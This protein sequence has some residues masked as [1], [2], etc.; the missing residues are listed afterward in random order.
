MKALNPMKSIFR[1]SAT[2]LAL[3]FL[4]AQSGNARAQ[5]MPPELRA[6]I[7]RLFDGHDQ[8]VRTVTLTRDGY[9]ATTTSTNPVMAA[10]LTAHVSQMSARLES[11]LM[12]RRWDPAF[13][14]YVRHYA[15]MKHEFT[16]LADGLKA[17]VTGLTPT[18]VRVAQNHA[19]IIADFVAHGWSGHDRSHPA[20]A[21]AGASDSK[22]PIEA[23][24]CVGCRRAV[25]KTTKSGEESK[26]ACPGECSQPAS[27]NGLKHGNHG[28]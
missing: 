23:S 20:V 11:G 8:L 1:I 24:N 22:A 26:P 14:Q 10:A 7:H 18:A 4:G 25:A 2:L 16:P 6:N 17:T 15:D 5:G 28:K 19:Q 12:I 9:T 3:A 13:E 27:T 21:A